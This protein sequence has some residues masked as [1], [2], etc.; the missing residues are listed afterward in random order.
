MQFKSIHIHAQ[1]SDDGVKR[2]PVGHRLDGQRHSLALPL[3]PL[4]C[5]QPLG[6]KL[7]LVRA[8]EHPAV[9]RL[10]C[11]RERLVRDGGDAHRGDDDEAGLLLGRAEL[12]GDRAEGVDE[13][14]GDEVGRVEDEAAGYGEFWLSAY[15]DRSVKGVRGKSKLLLF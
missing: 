11:E 3:F 9:E 7:V 5:E 10:E 4:V 13:G 2:A 8:G 14:A 6:P 1:E 12:V 15:S